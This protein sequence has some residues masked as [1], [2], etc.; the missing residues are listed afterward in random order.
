IYAQ[1]ELWEKA[2]DCYLKADLKSV[3]AE[4]L[5]KAGKWREAARCYRE[6][7][8]LRH[9]AAMYVKSKDWQLAAEA[10]EAVFVDEGPKAMKD[11]RKAGEMAKLVRQAGKLFLKAEQ[12]ERAYK[13]F[14][15]G[16]CAAEAGEVASRL[17]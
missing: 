9:A 14:E 16:G 10:L 1:Q 2:A 7:D 8:F 5:E 17:G 4:M 11:P 6:S 3:A 13:M 12:P 15:R